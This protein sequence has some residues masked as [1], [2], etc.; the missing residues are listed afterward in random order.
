MLQQQKEENRELNKKIKKNDKQVSIVNTENKGDNGKR[1]STLT[2]R[3]PSSGPR[4]N[5]PWG[6]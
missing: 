4:W 6:P 3:D 2:V 1:T 5:C